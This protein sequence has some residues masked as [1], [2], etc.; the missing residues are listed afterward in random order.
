MFHD[1]NYLQITTNTPM[2]PAPRQNNADHITLSHFSK[3]EVGTIL[4]ST[5]SS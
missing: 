3:I 5:F 1:L 2:V 4:P